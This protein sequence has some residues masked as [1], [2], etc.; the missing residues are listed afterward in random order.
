MYTAKPIVQGSTLTTSPAVYYTAPTGTYTRITQISLTNTDTVNRTI[1]IHIAPSSST[2]GTADTII[3]SK[4]LAAGETWVP[5][6]VL[7]VTLA[8]AGTLQLSASQSG[9][10]VLKASGIELS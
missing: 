1:A 5:Y 9:V 2:P 3:Q 6:Q 10:V 4:T 8:P 7:G